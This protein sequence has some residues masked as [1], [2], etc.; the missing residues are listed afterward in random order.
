MS[1]GEELF[2]ALLSVLSF[3]KERRQNKTKKKRVFSL[4][5]SVFHFIFQV[6][7]KTALFVEEDKMDPASFLFS[8]SLGRF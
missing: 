2:T 5:E 1:A 3:R 6:K 8:P 7:E 4:R